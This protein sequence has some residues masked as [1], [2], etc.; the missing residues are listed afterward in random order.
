MCLLC[1]VRV[2][3]CGCRPACLAAVDEGCTKELR[4]EAAHAV[5]KVLITT[6]PT[7]LS[8]HARSGAIKPLLLLCREVCKENH[9]AQ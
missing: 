5:A 2:C 6:N 7:L 3:V 1:D 9:S 4:R 8:E